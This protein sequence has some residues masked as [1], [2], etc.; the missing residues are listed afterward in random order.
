MILQDATG[1][2][3][4]STVVTLLVTVQCRATGASPVNTKVDFQFTNTSHATFEFAQ[5]LTCYP[6]DFANQ[7][8]RQDFTARPRGN[9]LQYSSAFVD[10]KPE[11][12]YD[13]DFSYVHVSLQYVTPDC[14]PA[15]TLGYIG[16]LIGQGLQLAFN[17]FLFAINGL[18]FAG[19]VLIWFVASVGIFFGAIPA[20]FGMEGAP[21]LVT[22][23]FGILFI[24]LLF[25]LAF[26][27]VSRI[28]GVGSA[29]G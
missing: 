20:L 24:A 23:S 28:R 5:Y 22:G 16:C 3:L 6:G 13:A 4:S 19:Q 9:I 14:N 7:T 25:Y 8:L 11:G 12:P 15:D 21:P 18:V 27:F 10:I 1:A 17:I 29:P 2:D 26:V